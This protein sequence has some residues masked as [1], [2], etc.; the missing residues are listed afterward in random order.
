MGFDGGMLCV[1]EEF[2]GEG[3]GEGSEGGFG[4]GVGAVP[5]EGE[6]GEEGGD[7]NYVFGL[8]RG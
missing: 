6:E 4:G 7:E 2:L 1:K 5:D 8:W 3:F